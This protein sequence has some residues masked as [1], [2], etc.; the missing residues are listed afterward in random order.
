MQCYVRRHKSERIAWQ[1]NFHSYGSYYFK[2][3]KWN[4][5]HYFVD[6]KKKTFY[7]LYCFI[8]IIISSICIT[9][10]TLF[11]RINISLIPFTCI[12]LFLRKRLFTICE[13]SNYFIGNDFIA[14]AST[15]LYPGLLLQA[16]PGRKR[17]F[18]QHCFL[19]FT[20]S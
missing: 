15:C 2:K 14:V 3:I 17:S 7:L 10:N 19:C 9:S 16:L 13:K 11:V 20:G 18:A 5:F 1:G 8:C 6:V 12:I 4:R